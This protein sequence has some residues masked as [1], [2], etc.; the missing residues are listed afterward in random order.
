[1]GC[2]SSL[3]PILDVVVV[4]TDVTDVVVV[5][6]GGGGGGGVPH[7]TYHM[8]HLRLRS[9]SAGLFTFFFTFLLLNHHSGKDPVLPDELHV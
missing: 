7:V 4:V 1:M 3:G 6:G 2:L 5:G 8:P 9:G